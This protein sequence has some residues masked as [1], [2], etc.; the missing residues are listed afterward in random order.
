VFGLGYKGFG[1]QKF[2]YSL[3]ITFNMEKIIY[4]KRI[5]FVLV[6]VILTFWIINSFIPLGSCHQVRYYETFH[7]DVCDNMSFMVNLFVNIFQ[8]ITL[9]GSA[10]L[11]VIALLYLKQNSK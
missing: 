7:W 6:I 11:I 8:V 10:Y 5:F 2:K 1:E 9:L 4:S 3:I